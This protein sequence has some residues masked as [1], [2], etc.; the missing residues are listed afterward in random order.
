VAEDRKFLR[1]GEADNIDS[2]VLKLNARC[3]DGSLQNIE[4][5]HLG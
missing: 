4:A 2:K 5:Q 1:Y 3:G